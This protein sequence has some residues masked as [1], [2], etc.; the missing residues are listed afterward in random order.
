VPG[1]H[2]IRHRGPV[3]ATA[4]TG[5]VASYL[6]AV[7]EPLPA[8]E[9]DLTRWVNGAPDWLASG[10]FPVMQLGTLVAPA[11]AAIAIAVWRRDL[12]LAG[13]TFAVGVITWFGAKGVKRTVE[14]GRPREYLPGVDVREGDGTGL[15][16]V[17]GHAAVAA[18]TAVM[19]AAATPRRW[20]WV[21]AVAAGL[22]GIAR[23]VHGVH[24]PADVV[25]GWAFGTL[26]ALGALEVVDRIGPAVEQ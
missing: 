1:S 21:L 19:V 10:L 12:V 11:L 24:L 13:A 9:L 3:A 20:R 26:I 4:A 2:S 22:V 14:R 25:G 23:I 18:A 8:W 15:G 7:R 5:L 16:Y 6:V 17:S